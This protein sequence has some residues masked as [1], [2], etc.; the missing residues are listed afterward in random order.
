MLQ[1]GHLQVSKVKRD[2]LTRAF[3][4]QRAVQLHTVKKKKD[5]ETVAA[6]NFRALGDNV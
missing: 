6:R 3:L 5:V 1:S 2:N 4:K